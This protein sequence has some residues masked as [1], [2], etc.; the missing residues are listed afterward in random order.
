MLIKKE[1]FYK[2]IKAYPYLQY[3]TDQIIN[4]KSFKS[5]NCYASF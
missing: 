5:K 2:L 1:V 4:G 3:T